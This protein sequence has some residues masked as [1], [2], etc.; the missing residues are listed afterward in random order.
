M[1][2]HTLCQ[3]IIHLRHRRHLYSSRRRRRQLLLDIQRLV[4]HRARQASN[5]SSVKKLNSMI[6]F[7]ILV[8]FLY[9]FKM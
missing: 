2:L 7:E 8:P 6:R 4:V 9:Q 5:R 1:L 3:L